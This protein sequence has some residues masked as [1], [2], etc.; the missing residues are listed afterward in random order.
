L[1]F[2][3]RSAE[4]LHHHPQQTTRISERLAR[5]RSATSHVAFREPGLS[6]LS[7]HVNHQC[8]QS[9]FR[10]PTS[11]LFSLSSGLG[12]NNNLAR[13]LRTSLLS[14]S[15]PPSQTACASGATHLNGHELDF[16]NSHYQIPLLSPDDAFFPF[17]LRDSLSHLA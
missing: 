2:N 6:S 16:P 15:L 8:K 10:S 12:N 14:S 13:H 9:F 17:S 11:P 3:G 1:T 5:V 4:Q 7:R